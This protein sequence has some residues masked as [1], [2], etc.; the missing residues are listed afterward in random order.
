MFLESDIANQVG[1][2]AL[3]PTIANAVRIPVIA[4]GGIG[5]ARTIKAALTLGAAAVQIGTAYLLC[6]EAKISPLYRAALSQAQGHDTVLTNVFTGRPARGI[7]NRAIRELGPMSP[8]A[9][10]FPNATNAMLPLRMKAEAKESPDFTSLWSGQA[11]H[12][13][14]ELPATALTRELALSATRP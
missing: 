12:L 5:D 4:A 11:P 7:A 13:A 8:I 9:P 6:P 1:T 14:R 10:A 2:F 3:V